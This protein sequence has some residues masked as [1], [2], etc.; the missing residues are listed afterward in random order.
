MELY[1][2]LEILGAA[3]KY[4]ASCS[5]SGSNRQGKVGSAALPG[6]CHSWA[7]D[8]RCISLLKVLLSNKC[9]YNCAYCKN[10]T[11]SDVPRAEF[12]PEEL[13]KI[14]ESFYARNY[15]EGLFL[16]SAVTRNPDYT[17]ERML[18]VMRLLRQRGF[19]GYIHCK[20]IPGASDDLVRQ[21]GF[22]A[23]RMSVNI[24]LPSQSSLQLLA[25]KKS[26][27]DI[28]NPMGVIRN[29]IT[30]ARDKKSIHAPEPFV[31]A[32]QST[33]M[34]VGASP[35]TD[36]QILLLSGALYR[37]YELKRVYYSAY[38]PVTNHPALPGITKPPL[39][40]EHR[41]YQA[42]WLMRFYNFSSDEILDERLPMLDEYLDPKCAWALRHMEY[43][44]VEVNRAPLNTLLR[45]PGIGNISARRILSAR[46]MAKLTFSDLKALGVVLKRAAYFIT[47]SGKYEPQ[48]KM[49]PAYVYRALSAQEKL[50]VFDAGIQTSMFD[51]ARELSAMRLLGRL[52]A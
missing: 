43:F 2:K 9:I 18:E 8:G 35:E 30:E 21:C 14:T 37:N 47:C 12:A 36:R 28:L 10:S 7:N 16:S 52:Q 22:L 4:D 40:R 6:I 24:E 5:S 48:L 50:P 17:M 1:E 27:L 41:L 13:V 3:A 11:D 45:V 26:K 33:Q 38:V 20:A 39:L 32:G 23:D 19:G 51:E 46:R 15:I 42:D 49:S 29:A 44:P 34:I 25:P 31:P